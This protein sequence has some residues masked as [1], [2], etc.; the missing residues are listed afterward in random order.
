[1]KERKDGVAIGRVGMIIMSDIKLLQQT[2]HTR[3]S[4]HI[5]TQRHTPN[6][7]KETA[8]CGSLNSSE[9]KESVDKE[10]KISCSASVLLPLCSR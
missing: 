9:K 4:S 6:L 1:M 5:H 2:A 8:L 3:T 7:Y 10:T